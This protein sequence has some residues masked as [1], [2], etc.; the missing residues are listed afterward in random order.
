MSEQKK[1]YFEGN[2]EKKLKHFNSTSDSN[3]QIS[4]NEKKLKLLAIERK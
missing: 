2:N 4:N 1:T 3:Q